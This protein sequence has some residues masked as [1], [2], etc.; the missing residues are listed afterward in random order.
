MS[1]FYRI[2]P[3][4]LFS[5]WKNNVINFQET[6]VLMFVTSKANG[7]INIPVNESFS[8]I[9]NAI[10]MKRQNINSILKSLEKKGLIK[11]GKK[12]YVLISGVMNLITDSVMNLITDNKQILS[13]NGTES[14]HS[15]VMNLITDNA[16]NSITHDCSVMNLI[17]GCNEINDSSVMNLITPLSYSKKDNKNLYKKENIIKEKSDFD[18]SEFSE[19]IQEALK[20]FIEMRKAKKDP[21]TEYAFKLIKNKIK[22]LSNIESEQIEIINQSTMSNWSGVFPLKEQQQKS[23]GKGK[24]WDDGPIVYRELTAEELF[25]E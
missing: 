11:K 12:G 6:K 25:G 16:I 8:Q 22:K 15:G 24:R 13:I 19:P 2:D 17:T 5:L 23:G 21:M 18:L 10:G 14:V 7:A 20:G 9:G 3:D 1:R 4:W